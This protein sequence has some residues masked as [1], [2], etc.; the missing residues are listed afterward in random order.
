MLL[1][2]VVG[3]KRVGSPVA[4]V[5]VGVEGRGPREKSGLGR[6]GR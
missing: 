6:R 5:E 3:G 2:I 1:P 4:G